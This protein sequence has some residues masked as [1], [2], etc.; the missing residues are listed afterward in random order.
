MRRK[1]GPAGVSGVLFVPFGGGKIPSRSA[2]DS[3]ESKSD[4]RS[5]CQLP[6]NSYS[7]K[8]IN[9]RE[10]FLRVHGQTN[11]RKEP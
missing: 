5:V 2:L 1:R 4:E 10:G 9:W 8:G 3:E 11:V 6:L 7:Y